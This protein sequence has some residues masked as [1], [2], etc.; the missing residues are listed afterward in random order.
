MDINNYPNTSRKNL[1]RIHSNFKAEKLHPAFFQLLNSVYREYF[2]SLKAA[3]GK[4]DQQRHEITGP[5]LRKVQ[6]LTAVA[7]EAKSLSNMYVHFMNG[8]KRGDYA[9]NQQIYDFADDNN[10]RNLE[11]LKKKADAF[12]KNPNKEALASLRLF[13]I[14]DVPASRDKFI[15]FINKCD[16]EYVDY[17]DKEASPSGDVMNPITGLDG[18]PAIPVRKT[19]KIGKKNHKKHEDFGA[20][21][22]KKGRGAKV[23]KQRRKARKKAAEARERYNKDFTN[24]FFRPGQWVIYLLAFFEGKLLIRNLLEPELT[25]EVKWDILWTGSSLAFTAFVFFSI[26]YF[27]KQKGYDTILT[28]RIIA[29]ISVPAYHY[30]FFTL[31]IH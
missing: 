29:Y 15:T 1:E 22:P 2:D 17:L 11:T 3:K 13:L 12:L 27:T 9:Y 21:K 19:Q 10:R 31:F 30:F 20:F 24:F 4:N 26:W 8:A 6:G 5:P 7:R 25:E 14:D 18:D 16:V 28:Y 23:N